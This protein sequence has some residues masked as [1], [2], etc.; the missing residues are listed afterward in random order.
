MFTEKRHD[1]GVIELVIDN[2]PVNAFSI[3]LLEELA[4]RVRDLGADEASHVII[5]RAAGRGFSAGGDV[6]EVEKLKGFAGILG[7]SAGSLGV[8]LAVAECSIPVIAAVHGHCIGVGVLV[9]A[10]ADIVIG[11]V[12]AR[13]ILAEVDNGATAG[14]IQALRFMPEKR[15]RAAM[16][17][18]EPITADELFRMG[19]IYRLVESYEAMQIS[20]LTIAAAIASK[21]PEAMRRLKKS[22]NNSSDTASLE[23][24]YRAEMSYTYE[25]NMMGSASRGRQAFI[26]KDRDGYA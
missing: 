4:Q 9:A 23:K 2:P 25:L 24:L 5:L 11:T 22:L 20:A 12:D 10:S 1:N 3:G 6:K 15:A 14:A 7:Q 18:T 8:S 26:D 16:M 13:F 19:S 17:T 21:A